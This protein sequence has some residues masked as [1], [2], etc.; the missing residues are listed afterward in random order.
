MPEEDTMIVPEEFIRLAGG[1][2]QGSRD[3][4]ST[5]EDWVASAI[6]R[7]EAKQK[8]VVKQ[9]LTELLNE[10]NDAAE[11]HKVWNST[12]ADYYFGRDEREMRAF[13]AMIR[14]AM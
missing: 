11:L 12:P 3:E 1:F 2:Y 4:F 8:A 9:F 13:L 5:P 10:P 14:D 7:L 6:D